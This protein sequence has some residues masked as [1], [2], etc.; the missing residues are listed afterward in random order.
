M[1]N[2]LKP[3]W[4][5]IDFGEGIEQ[6]PSV[7]TKPGRVNPLDMNIVLACDDWEYEVADDDDDIDVCRFVYYFPKTGEI[8]AVGSWESRLE[9]I[10]DLFNNR[11]SGVIQYCEFEDTEDELYFCSEMVIG[12]RFV[13]R[14]FEMDIICRYNKE[15]LRYATLSQPKEIKRYVFG[16]EGVIVEN[17]DHTVQESSAD[18]LTV[19]GIYDTLI[20]ADET[21]YDHLMKSFVN[22]VNIPHKDEI[23]RAL[24]L[25]KP[26]YPGLCLEA[27]TAIY[28]K[29][30]ECGEIPAD[31]P[32]NVVRLLNNWKHAP[33][34]ALKF[35]RD[36]VVVT[37]ERE[38]KYLCDTEPTRVYFDKDR[39]YYFAYNAVTGQ[40]CEEDLRRYVSENIGIRSAYVKKALF[41]NT[42]MGWIIDSHESDDSDEVIGIR[43]L[44]LMKAYLAAEQAA[45]TDPHILNVVLN[46]IHYGQ[47]FDDKRSLSSVFGVSGAQL[48]YLKNVNLPS[49]IGYFG[50]CMNSEDFREHF[51]DVKKRIFAVAFFLEPD[52]SED[53]DGRIPRKTVFEAY[54]TLNSL[55]K[56]NPEDRDMLAR[57]YRDYLAMRCNYLRYVETMS[58]NDPL[59]DEIAAYGEMPVNIKP[60]RIREYH[61]KL[62]RVME[63]I[64]CSR[65]IA[66]YSEDISKRYKEEAR[67]YEYRKGKYA[68]LMPGNASEIVRE[69]RELEHCVGRAGY[70]QAMAGHRCTIL[71]LREIDNP[72]KPLLTLEVRGESIKQ[73]YGFRDSLNHDR[74]IAK[75]I[76]E[77]AMIHD[78]EVDAVIYEDI[79]V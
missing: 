57:V 61:N 1:K 79:M 49:N 11:I 40:W 56:R 45:K 42:C 48:K 30:C 47:F 37:G 72:D 50:K 76:R 70:I 19:S 28:L 75:F 64:D 38:C 69:G 62:N 46:S 21:Y 7:T 16:S 15:S 67:N 27:F 13:F 10:C 52:S 66:E 8:K 74:D 14:I 43:K 53:G 51:P 17:P 12:D 31:T 22:D 5:T 60:S 36:L 23:I 6:I 26:G 59:G 2:I 58:E 73:C 55:E 29:A 54:K 65:Q 32:E 71:F 25:V 68:M 35:T 20:D 34:K 24:P 41:K 3:T 4:E 77:Y 39:A 63:T 78:Y 9:D 33:R 44:I 18:R